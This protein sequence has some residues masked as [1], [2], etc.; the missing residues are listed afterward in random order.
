MALLSS[1]A[2]RCC[3]KNSKDNGI[4]VAELS[5]LEVKY[6]WKENTWKSGSLVN[7]AG[8]DKWLDQYGYKW[9]VQIGNPDRDP[10]W[11]T[12]L[13]KEVAPGNDKNITPASLFKG[14]C[15]SICQMYFLTFKEYYIWVTCKEWFWFHTSVVFKSILH[16]FSRRRDRIEWI[17]WH[18]TA[19]SSFTEPCLFKVLFYPSILPISVSQSFLRHN[20]LCNVT[21]G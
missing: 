3:S 1:I 5:V 15:K 6:L 19:M 11:R 17:Q 13:T 20:F 14:L 8:Q 12:R 9:H 2:I 10:D 16:L 18:W 21:W 4:A 7:R